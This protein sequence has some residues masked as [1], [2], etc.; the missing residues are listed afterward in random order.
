VSFGD[1]GGLLAL[2]SNIGNYEENTFAAIPEMDVTLGYLIAPSLRF[3]VGYTLLYWN[4]VVRPGDH[5]DTSINPNLIP[6]VQV[7][8]DNR[9][10]F[11]LNETDI[12]AQGVSFGLDYRW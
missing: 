2:S 6:P 3:T 5:I 9:P 11:T 10:A 7:G 1:E 8:G 12:W 4:N